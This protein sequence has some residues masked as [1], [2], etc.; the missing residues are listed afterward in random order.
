MKFL[1]KEKP[2]FAIQYEGDNFGEIAEFCEN[3]DN[4]VTLEIGK[5]GELSINSI[6]LDA[7]DY[8][9]AN[10][11]GLRIFSPGSFEFSFYRVEIEEEKEWV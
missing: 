6:P 5:V 4:D 10:G 7:G 11:D 1:V 9:V 2:L 8:I 3:H